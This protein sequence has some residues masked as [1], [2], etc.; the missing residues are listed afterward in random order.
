MPDNVTQQLG[1]DASQALAVLSQLDTAFQTFEQRLR[2]T[3]DAMRLFNSTA[4]NIDMAVKQTGAAFQANIPEATKQVEKLTVSWGMMGRII[5]TQLVVRALS[6]IRTEFKQATESAIDF[7]TR[8][9]E[10]STISAG[11]GIGNMEQFGARI[12]ELSDQWN[13]GLS[14][15]TKALYDTVSNQIKQPMEFMESAAAFAKGSVTSMADAVRLGSGTLNAF[16][17]DTGKADEVFAKFNKTIELGAVTGTEL[18]NSFGRVAPRAQQLG[19]SIEELDA[20]FA[21]LT[22]RGLR[23]NEAATQIGGMLTA[24]IKPSEAMAKAMKELGFSSPEVM[25]KTLGIGG[26]MKALTDSVHGSAEELGKLFSNIRGYSGAVSIGAQANELYNK[27]LKDIQGTAANLNQERA[28]QVLNTDAQTVGKAFTQLSNIM[29]ADLGQALLRVG[30]SFIQLTGGVDTLKSILPTINPLLV[31]GTGLLSAYALAAFTGATANKALMGTFGGVAQGLLLVS[32]AIMGGKAIAKALSD[33][34]ADPVKAFDEASKKA[35]EQLRKQEA[36]KNRIVEEAEDKRVQIVLKAGQA[37]NRAYLQDV[38]N[39]K[40]ANDQLVASTERAL[41]QIVGT[42]TKLLDSLQKASEQS[43]EF[44][45]DSAN[46]I[47]DLLSKQEDRTFKRKLEGEDDYRKV[48]DLADRARAMADEA[49]QALDRAA[50][51][52][53]KEA[54]DRA[55]RLFSRAQAAGDEAEAIAKRTGNRALEAKAIEAINDTTNKQI[56]AELQLQKIQADRQALIDKEVQAQQEIVD[57]IKT[58]AKALTD[59][60]KV[61]DKE[62]K[63]LPE[64]QLDQ[65]AENRAKALMTIIQEGFNAKN[66]D[67]TGALGLAKFAAEFQGALSQKPID[68]AFQVEGGLARIQTQIQDTALS[69]LGSMSEGQSHEASGQPED[70]SRERPRGG[71]R[72]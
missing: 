34:Y 47:A 51:S 58:A 60:M 41:Q 57:R 55:E 7:Q 1:F 8:L 24:L 27:T 2:S 20:L 23:A 5:T 71:D 43:V 31:T 39:A 53:D 26:A 66:L 4:A 16:A 10:I 40:T 42:R 35:V 37:L 9:A 44:T 54:L 70:F 38:A 62:G 48:F 65:L 52:G 67:L 50:R 28:L 36:E 59:N 12:R 3:A 69:G 64:Q 29:T 56:T 25:V 6:E 22:I 49:T 45:R 72:R 15:A 18:A 13:I 19:V 14:D 32:E 11:T 33:A 61:F 63:L 30:S 17:L 46:R 68:L 21:I